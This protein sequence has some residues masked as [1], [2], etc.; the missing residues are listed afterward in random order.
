M[1]AL[2][3]LQQY[4]RRGA[5]PV[6]SGDD[7]MA[8]LGRALQDGAALRQPAL[9]EGLPDVVRQSILNKPAYG[10]G[11]VMPGPP[12]PLMEQEHTA[13]AFFGPQ[14]EEA[15]RQ[16]LGDVSRLKQ[17][18]LPLSEGEWLTTRPLGMS[19]YASPLN[20]MMPMGR[21]APLA[22]Y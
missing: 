11:Q 22:L 17:E 14:R 9:P 7:D 18:E 2:D 10:E 20:Q 13:G 15:L 3:L 21:R 6:S 5:Q 1:S 8:W 16:G 12:N 4:L 19:P